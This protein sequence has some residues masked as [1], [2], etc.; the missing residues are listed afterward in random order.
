MA[1]LPSNNFTLYIRRECLT[2][3]E[4]RVK[5]TDGIT[6]VDRVLDGRPVAP[7]SLEFRVMRR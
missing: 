4:S 7:Y 6:V 3:I 1:I 2:E 5:I